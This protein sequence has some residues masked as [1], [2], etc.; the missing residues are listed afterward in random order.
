MARASEL[1]REE[2]V[3]RATKLFSERGYASTSLRDIMEGFDVSGPAFYH[4]FESKELILAE[5]LDGALSGAESVLEELL[6]DASLSAA[7]RFLCAMRSHAE[8][9]WSNSDAARVLFVDNEL[10]STS[11]SGM[12]QT[13]MQQYTETLSDLYRLGVEEGTL[14]PHNPRTV[15]ALVLGMA[16]WGPFWMQP[17]AKHTDE[18]NTLIELIAGSVCEP[19][20]ETAA[21]EL[22]GRD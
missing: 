19:I 1:R 14:K 3:E 9:V 5:I 15:T 18:L 7:D 10:A 6:G 21:T 12:I 4:Y 2:I 16:N 11:T 20:F 8:A 17:G 22:R 13:R